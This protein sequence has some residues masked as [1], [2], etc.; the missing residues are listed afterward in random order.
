LAEAHSAAAEDVVYQDRQLTIT[1]TFRP[2]GFRLAGEIDTTNSTA[3]TEL[4]PTWQDRADD[5][6]LDI[7]TLVFCDV[8]GIRS[9]VAL[10]HSL[11]PRRQVLL[12]GLDPHLERVIKAAGWDSEAGLSICRC[13]DG[14]E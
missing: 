10:A 3:V 9:L 8:S 4:L 11:G 5:P 13:R 7:R 2:P 6:H 12:H 14:A 1:R